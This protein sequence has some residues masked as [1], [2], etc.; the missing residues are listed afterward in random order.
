MGK[1]GE[2]FD[3]DAKAGEVTEVCEMHGGGGSL[4]EACSSS[5]SFFHF[6]F[7]FVIMRSLFLG[8]KSLIQRELWRKQNL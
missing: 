3:P 8:T 5:S 4:R 1:V 2:W 7:V 6:S